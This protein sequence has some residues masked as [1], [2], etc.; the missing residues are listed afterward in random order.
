[1]T[2]KQTPLELPLTLRKIIS[3]AKLEKGWHYGAGGPAAK[4]TLVATIKV[5][6]Q[7]VMWGLSRTDAFPG[8]DGEVQL[9]AYFKDNVV[10]ITIDPTLKFAVCYERNDKEELEAEGLD[11]AATRAIIG[12]VAGKI[13]G[14]SDWS[15]PN[16]LI[17]PS[18][19]SA[20]WHSSGPMMG[21][22]YSVRPAP[23]LE[24]A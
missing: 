15:I 13:W 11:W 7:L 2:D 6:R 16:T 9:T 21:S 1:M 8:V 10:S 5:W 22:R 23:N 12:K 20:T 17:S 18:T 3:F 4:D 14:L 24:A 19:G